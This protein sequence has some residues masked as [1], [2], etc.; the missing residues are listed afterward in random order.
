MTTLAV[1]R[2]LDGWQGVA[3]FDDGVALHAPVSKTKIEADDYLKA[4]IGGQIPWREHARA[5]VKARDELAAVSDNMVTD[6]A[7]TIRDILR[8]PT[9]VFA[10]AGQRLEGEE[11]LRVMVH[12][13]IFAI[14]DAVHSLANAIRVTVPLLEDGRA[15]ATRALP[16][17]TVLGQWIDQVIEVAVMSAAQMGMHDLITRT[18][19]GF[20]TTVHWFPDLDSDLLD[21]D[22][23]EEMA[24]AQEMITAKRANAMTEKWLANPAYREHLCEFTDG[25]AEAQAL[26]AQALDRVASMR[27][28]HH[29]V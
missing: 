27:P 15:K 24:D 11:A 22:E 29:H 12:A 8:H 21:R 9:K 19:G 18:P 6:R 2:R 3:T 23:A 10:I 26:I 17:A 28:Q 25:S 14:V 16:V 4:C 20:A 7:L 1:L 5:L 13:E